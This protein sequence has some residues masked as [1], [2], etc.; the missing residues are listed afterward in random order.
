MLDR[1]IP[2]TSKISQ[3][4]WDSCKAGA[5]T[6]QKCEDCGH[7]A[8]YPVYICPECTSRKLAWT[9]VSG[10]GTVYTYTAADSSIFGNEPI[11]VALV[12]LEEGAMMMSNI[13]NA[14]PGEVGIGTAVTLT[15]QP[16]SDDF[17]LPVFEVA[18]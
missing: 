6:I 17:T 12:E 16:I 18:K 11:I 10:R 9:P 3:P 15:Y 14:E 4:F 8:Y 2:E 13:I 5:M 1:F 7:Y